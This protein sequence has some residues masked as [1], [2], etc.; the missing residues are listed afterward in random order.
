MMMQMSQLFKPLTSLFQGYHIIV[1]PEDKSRT[2]TLRVSGFSLKVL[3]VGVVLAV[4]LCLVSIL[5]TIHYQNMVVSMKRDT[6]EN[7]QLMQSKREL[8]EKISVLEKN[9]ALMDGTLGS[10]G[11]VMDIDVNSMKAGLGPVADADLYLPEDEVTSPLESLN[12]DAESTISEWLESSGNLTL[13]QF[14]EKLNGIKNQSTTIN[15]KIQDLFDQSKDKIRF[16]NSIPSIMPVGGWVTSDF[17]M[18]DH[19]ISHHYK[20]HEGLDIA[21]PTGAPILAPADGVVVYT[22]YHGGHG[23]IVVLDH[24][25]GITTLYAHTSKVDIKLGDHVARGQLIANVGSSGSTTGP[26]LHYE[27]RVD[28][29]PTDPLHYIAQK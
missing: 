24:G 23:L 16:A 19:P 28:G 9:L 10:L 7:E 13:D 22:G 20:L 1:V 6:Y 8:V 2:K 11:K 5:A 3:I 18:R 14:N 25:Y 4:P 27:V 12:L 26:H 29:I 17:G 15:K 21:S